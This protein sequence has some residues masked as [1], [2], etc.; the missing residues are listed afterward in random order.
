MVPGPP[1][2]GTAQAGNLW[3]TCLCRWGFPCVFPAEVLGVGDANPDV[4]I[5]RSKL[6]GTAFTWQSVPGLN[7]RFC[8]I[9]RNKDCRRGKCLCVALL[10]N[11]CSCPCP[12]VQANGK[13]VIANWLFTWGL[14][15]PDRVV[16]AV[17]ICN[18]HMFGG[19]L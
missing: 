1:P 12:G 14:C 9:V 10:S 19:V 3:C 13:Q 7:T 6:T 16:F 5:E 2:A 18:S 8:F 15:F 17:S 4:M 11:V